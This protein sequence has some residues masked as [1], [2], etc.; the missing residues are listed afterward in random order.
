M[1]VN[2]KDS[3]KEADGLVSV[4]TAKF[5]SLFPIDA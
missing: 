4:W 3:L 2:I 5:G 1:Y